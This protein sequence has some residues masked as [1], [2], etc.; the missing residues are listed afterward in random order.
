MVKR[1]SKNNPF[2]HVHVVVLRLQHSAQ[3]LSLQVVQLH[4]LACL[5]TLLE[6]RTDL[7]F[8]TLFVHVDDDG[9]F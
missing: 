8:S 4:P 6:F 2:F 9:S 3:T 5:T 7:R 1:D